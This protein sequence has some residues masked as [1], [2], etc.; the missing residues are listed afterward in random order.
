M[1]RLRAIVAKASAGGSL[2]NI[3]G[4]VTRIGHTGDVVASSLTGTQALS[5]GHVGSIAAPKIT[6]DIWYQ[7]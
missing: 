5:T 3:T 7:E 6:G 2:R 1:D 4:D